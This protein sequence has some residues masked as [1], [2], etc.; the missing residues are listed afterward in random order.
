M[1]ITLGNKN[2]LPVLSVATP[3]GLPDKDAVI[4]YAKKYNVDDAIIWP[5]ATARRMKAVQ[6]LTD[7]AD[8]DFP[9]KAFDPLLQSQIVWALAQLSPRDS[10]VLFERK[11]AEIAARGG[12]IYTKE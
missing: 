9:K 5:D 7:A 8:V 4:E 3:D 2:G 11:Y 1:K 6:V 10:G 12:V